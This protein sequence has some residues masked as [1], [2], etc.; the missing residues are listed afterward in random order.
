MRRFE[1]VVVPE[2]RAV[3]SLRCAKT[4]A[5]IKSDHLSDLP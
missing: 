3:T 2:G 4:A 1:G 5:R